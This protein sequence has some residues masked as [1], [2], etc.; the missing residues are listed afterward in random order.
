MRLALHGSPLYTAGTVD[1]CPSAE[2]A[3]LAGATGK[4]IIATAY[5]DSFRSPRTLQRHGLLIT[6]PH[7][8]LDILTQ[9]PAL[10]CAIA[11]GRVTFNGWAGFGGWAI[12]IDSHSTSGHTYRLY[13][14]HL[15]R[16]S[17]WTVGSTV[18]PG[19]IIGVTG[20]TGGET[21]AG[22]SP[23][24]GSHMAG[25]IHLHLALS[26]DGA[27]YDPA[28]DVLPLLGASPAGPPRYW[29]PVA[30]AEMQ[31]IRGI[32]TPSGVGTSAIIPAT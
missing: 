5:A 16:P 2:G 20:N 29:L 14:A 31:E 25:P 22:A 19:V 26:R 7:L 12:T 30:R 10:V 32:Y 3:P 9:R 13:Y 18:W 6:E 11:H 23:P 8:A 21:P 15:S 28:P 17:A 24:K 27:P 1:N 4:P